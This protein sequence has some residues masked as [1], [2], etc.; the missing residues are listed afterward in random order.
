[1]PQLRNQPPSTEPLSQTP[2]NG[3]ILIPLS[4]TDI[5]SNTSSNYFTS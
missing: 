3:I 2:E 4:A 1:M 5:H